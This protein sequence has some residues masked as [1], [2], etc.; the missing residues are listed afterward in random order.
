MKHR[1]APLLLACLLSPAAV[2]PLGGQPAA[3]PQRVA[4]VALAYDNRDRDL[5]LLGV[6]EFAG[7]DG[8]LA[9]ELTRHGWDARLW[10]SSPQRQLP[11]PAREA[12]SEANLRRF[13]KGLGALK[14]DDEVLVVLIGHLVALEGGGPD[15]PAE[16]LYFCPEDARYQ[17]LAKADDVK[18]EH[19]LLPLG[20]IYDS[21][22]VCPARKKLLVLVVATSS[23]LG[24]PAKYP[25]PLCSHL[26]KL[27]A[28]GGLAVLTSC[29]EGEFTG[30]RGDFID[31][32]QEGLAGLKADGGPTA[33]P[34][35]AP[36]PPRSGSPSP[37]TRWRRKPATTDTCRSRSTRRCWGGCRGTGC[38]R[39]SRL[40]NAGN[41]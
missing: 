31:R 5:P 20:E 32:L 25:R 16:K 14:A 26:P 40:G 6:R 33:R 4:L 2:S 28:P 9:R 8:R 39:A 35:T 38:W 7:A 15:K 30:T 24:K 19:R 23:A 22:K 17:K 27:P 41:C 36:S 37:G 34:A 1:L 21:L 3:P 13:L 12:P 29:A 11:P 10:A 18:A